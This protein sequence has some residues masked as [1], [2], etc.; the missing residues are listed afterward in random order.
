M[1]MVSTR[2]TA[3]V[4]IMIKYYRSVSQAT[5]MKLSVRGKFIVRD[6]AWESNRTLLN[7]RHTTWELNLFGA[8]QSL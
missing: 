2:A 5:L 7:E 1:M 8:A 4:I 6:T 3:M